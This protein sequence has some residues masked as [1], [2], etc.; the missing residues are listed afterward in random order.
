M[1][2][3]I[4]RV[5]NLTKKF[6]SLAAVDNVSLEVERGELLSIIGPNGAGKTTFFNLISGFLPK[7]GGRVYYKGEDITKMPAYRITGKGIGRSFQI[8]N[9]LPNLTVFKNVF[10]ARLAFKKKTNQFFMPSTLYRSEKEETEEILDS[11]KLLDKRNAMAGELSHGGKKNL[12]IGMAMALEPEVL[13]LDE[14]TAG[15]SPRETRETVELIK[16]F[17]TKKTIIFTEH[18]M[19]I[20][21]SIAERL[22]VLHQGEV[23]CEGHPETVKCD[24]LV[25]SAYLGEELCY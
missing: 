9:I 8:T 7:T 6:G 1:K 15:M 5:E 20:V 2:D 16:E 12:E 18:D 13:L 23:I 21:F 17:S 22:I 11:I 24:A 3:I 25:R 14:P 4:L 10:N 19:K